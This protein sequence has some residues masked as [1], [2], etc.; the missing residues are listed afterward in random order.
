MVTVVAEGNTA[1]S[2]GLR[3]AANDSASSE[4]SGGVTDSKVN[5]LEM[6]RATDAGEDGFALGLALG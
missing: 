1:S 5:E 6:D 4:L 3:T 2:E